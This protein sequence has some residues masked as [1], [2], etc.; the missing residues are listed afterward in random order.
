MQTGGEVHGH[1][2]V[3]AATGTRTRTRTQRRPRQPA[4]EPLAWQS[5]QQCPS[6]PR[7][8]G[9]VLCG[10]PASANP[11][12]IRE[13]LRR[14]ALPSLENSRPRP[15]PTN[16]TFDLPSPSPASSTPSPPRPLRH[17]TTSWSTRTTSAATTVRSFPLA[18]RR[19]L[20][21]RRVDEPRGY[22]RDRSRSPRRDGRDMDNTRA[23]SAS[24][25]GRDSRY[26]SLALPLMGATD[27]PPV[28]RPPS[29]ATLTRAATRAPTCSSL[30]S[31]PA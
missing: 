25:N 12:S 19:P 11:N 3:K 16:N 4:E 26:V 2:K 21:T 14:S 6:F 1:V 29:L 15:G 30:A 10:R 23:R 22:E 31:T 24:P 18:A 13:R 20:L 9:S 5:N 7:P 28:A 17:R 27:S 8:S